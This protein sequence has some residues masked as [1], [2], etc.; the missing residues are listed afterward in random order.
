[1]TETTQQKPGAVSSPT[2]V[3][4]PIPP[5]GP[6]KSPAKNKKNRKLVKNG[7]IA[8]VVLAIVGVGGYFLYDKVIKEQPVEQAAMTS[9]VMRGS[10]QSTVQ[11]NGITKAKDSATITPTAGGTILQLMVKEGDQVTEGQQLY[12]MD[13]A[14]ARK[15]VDDAQKV[16]TNTNKTLQALYDSVNDLNITAPHDGKMIKVPELKVND[17]VTKGQVVATI[18]DDTKLKLSL[19]YSYSFEND[20][21]VGQEA[22]ISIPSIMAPLTGKVEKINKVEYVVP[23]GSVLFEVV[24]VL[25]NPGTLTEGMEATATLTDANGGAIYPYKADQLKFYQTTEVKAKVAGPVEQV[26]LLNYAAVKAGQL[27]VRL[28][29]EDNDEEIATNENALKTATDKLKEAQDTLDKYNANAPISGTVISCNLVEGAKV[30]SGQGLTIADTSVMTVD[31]QVDERNIKYVKV[32]MMVDLNQYDTMFTGMVE[33]VSATGKAEN[34]VSAFPCVVK[35]DNP[36]GAI[37]TNM[38]LQYSFVA[39]QSDDC[40]LVPVQAVQYVTLPGAAAGEGDPGMMDGGVLPEGDAAITEGDAALPEG[41]ITPVEPQVEPS[42]DPEAEPSAEPEASAETDTSVNVT[43]DGGMAIAD[44]AVV[45]VAVP[46][47]GMMISGGGSM[48]FGPSGGGQSSGGA[49]TIVFVQGTGDDFMT[50]PPNAIEAD[51]AWEFPE[52]YFPVVVEVGLADTTNV[53][54]KSGLNEGDTVFIGYATQNAWG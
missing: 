9:M 51:P 8:V 17:D 12:R 21:Y 29:A 18:V 35:V 20:I 38:Y 30:E 46:R 2:T 11:G 23:E 50:P 14:D 27:L 3:T 6:K 47:S 34:G 42:A 33:S 41:D 26:N 48:S 28:G 16:V 45:D 54:I 36:D 4:S 37:L 25:E 1:M 10:I 53:E 22:Q 24:I 19:Y 5:S 44:G 7:I 32:G 49:A 39:S 13:D 40:L 52:G 31:I 15:A 43:T